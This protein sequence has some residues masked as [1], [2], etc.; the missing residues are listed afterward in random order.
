MPNDVR[1]VARPP[2]T[3]EYQRLRRAVGWPELDD[4]TVVSGLRNTLYSLCLLKEE[5]VIG[6]ARVIGDGA[7]Y[8]YIQ[9]VIVLPEFQGCGFGGRLMDAVMAFLN[10]H[11]RH[12]SFIGLMAAKEVKLFYEKYGFTERPADRPGMFLMWP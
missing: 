7:I 9:D 4:A 10:H 5:E 11:A 8:F 6:C 1:I 3:H 12:N 2:V